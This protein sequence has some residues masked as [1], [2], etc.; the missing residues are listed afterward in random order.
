MTEKRTSMDALL[1]AAS[2][3]KQNRRVTAVCNCWKRRWQE[4]TAAIQE[5]DRRLNEKLEILTEQ[6]GRLTETVN[7]VDNHID[8]VA[9]TVEQQAKTAQTLADIVQRLLDRT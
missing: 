6:V 8:R 1:E 3:S 9:V 5:L 2:A 7:R 4:N